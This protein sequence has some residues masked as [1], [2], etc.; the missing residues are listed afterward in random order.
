MELEQSRD[1]LQQTIGRKVEWFAPPGG[2]VNERCVE[3]ARTYGYRFV[4][5]MRWGY[6][7]ITQTGEIPCIPVL[8]RTGEESFGR[9]INGNA[10][11]YGFQLKEATKRVLGDRAYVALRDQFESA[12]S[13]LWRLGPPP[14]QTVQE[15]RSQPVSRGEM[16]MILARRFVTDRIQAYLWRD[17][18]EFPKLVGFDMDVVVA[19]NR[20]WRK[21]FPL[22]QDTVEQCGW[23]ILASIR[24]GTVHTIFT[25]RTS[26]NNDDFLQIDL[27]RYLTAW[28]VPYV[29]LPTLIERAVIV[30]GAPFLSPAAGATISILGPTLMGIRPKARYALALAEAQRTDPEGVSDV[31]RQALGNRAE[32]L[33]KPGAPVVGLWRRAFLNAVWQRPITVCKV[34]CC[35]ARDRL[36]SFLHP[37]GTMISVS[38]PDGVG[39]STTLKFLSDLATRRICTRVCI[40]H[41]RPYVIPRLARFLPRRAREKKLTTRAYE[42]RSS[43]P[44]SWLRL[45]ILILDYNLG[46]WLRIRPGLARGEMVVFDRDFL[47]IRADP[48]IRG[49]CLSDGILNHV[50]SL[51]PQP[52]RRVVLTARPHT[53]TSRTQELSLIEADEQITRYLTL[54]STHANCLVLKTDETS[55]RELS[56]RII[57]W[58]S[59]SDAQ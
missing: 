3:A 13:S 35:I 59:Q 11:F 28:A 27:H 10:S 33:L 15:V 19:N 51:I 40:H 8:P 16:Y 55:P 58:L 57:D 14:R 54:A 18:D 17:L 12:R 1:M 37:P 6:A 5:T 43:Y 48:R 46:Y 9:I 38:G 45:A 34:L 36:R 44:K 4:R 49:I 25:G 52:D 41:T 24:R 22:L 32:A 42:R 50:E 23:R 21:I 56:S 47:D 20:S 7:S 30:D 29:D 26:V 31:I 39:K 53:I 2:F